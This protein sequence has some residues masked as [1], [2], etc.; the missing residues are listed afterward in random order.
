M[1]N[2]LINKHIKIWI[3]H[4]S[5]KQPLLDGHSICPFSKKANYRI[6]QS[7]TIDIVPILSDVDLLIYIFPDSL[8][9]DDIREYAKLLNHQYPDLLFLPDHKDRNT[10]IKKINSN[11]G[12][13][14]LILCQS[15]K[16]IIT[17]REKLKKTSYYSF[18]D[19]DYLDE[20]LKS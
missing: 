17:A 8:S 13:Y 11:N 3:D 15:R 18:W 1:G 16:D 5:N 19:E 2:N 7:D 6:I 9:Q 4:L 12:K 20:I 14:N 10:F